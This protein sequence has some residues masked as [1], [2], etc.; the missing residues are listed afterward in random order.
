MTSET[1][2]GIRIKPIRYLGND[3]RRVNS[4]LR[5]IGASWVRGGGCWNLPYF[6][7]PQ[8]V[9]RYRRTWHSR[10]RRRSIAQRLAEKCHVSTKE[11]VAEVIPL[12]KV[13]YKDDPS[14]SEGISSWLELDEKEA[15][16][17]RK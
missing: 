13:I 14:M 2:G 10:R 6:R 15:E 7:P 4:S 5:G 3:W 9:W 8:L 11:A 16:W 1:P 12:L 17:L